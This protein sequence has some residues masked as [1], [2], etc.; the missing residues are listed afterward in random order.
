MQEV[1]FYDLVR[2]DLLDFAVIAAK[3]GGKW[4]FCKHKERDTYE[5]PGGHREANETIEEAARRELWEETGAVDFTL[6][7]VSVYGV[8]SE[9]KQSYGMLYYADIYKFEELPPLEIE[10]IEEFDCLPDNWTYPYIQ[11]KL[12]EKIL[13]TE[14]KIP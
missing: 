5:C 7:K 4:V 9:G 2:D 3:H 14:I 6:H 11:P 12:F 1:K 10:R 8:C 13:E